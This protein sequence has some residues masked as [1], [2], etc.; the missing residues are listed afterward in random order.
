MRRRFNHFSGCSYSRFVRQLLPLI[1]SLLVISAKAQVQGQV[2]D[3][4]TGDELVGVAIY[5]SNGK[6]ADFSGLN[7]TYH[8]RHIAPGTYTLTK[9]MDSDIPAPAS[10][11]PGYPNSYALGQ[12]YNAPA[13]VGK[14]NPQFV[15]FPLPVTGALTLYNF[16]G[17]YNFHLNSGSPA[18]GKGYTSF[19]PINATS[20]V[21]SAALKATVTPPS[22]D[23]GAFPMDNS[24]NQH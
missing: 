12:V 4:K 15:N 17:N 21:S 8:L 6:N 14:N 19:T 10:F 18:I 3:S 20:A 7:G 23:L 11:Y 9:P 22:I 2:T 5:L 1:L 24:G 16:V 13:L